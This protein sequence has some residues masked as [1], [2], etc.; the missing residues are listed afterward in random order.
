MRW[1]VVLVVVAVLGGAAFWL[2]DSDGLSRSDDT[3]ATALPEQEAATPVVLPGLEEDAEPTEPTTSEPP[4]SSSTPESSS[5]EDRSPRVSTSP[6]GI[7][8]RCVDQNG[9]GLPGLR[10]GRRGDASGRVESDAAG[11]IEWRQPEGRR[12]LPDSP[13]FV[14]EGRGYARRQFSVELSPGE[15]VDLGDLVIERGGTLTGWVETSAG[16]RLPGVEVLVLSADSGEEDER[17]ARLSGPSDRENA[18]QLGETDLR[19]RFQID[20]VPPGWVRLWTQGDEDHRWTFS[21]PVEVRADSHRNGITLIVEPLADEDRIEGIVY[22]PDGSP[23]PEAQVSYRYRAGG[24]SGSGSFGTD[25]AGRFRRLTPWRGRYRLH[26][27]DP[28]GELG[29]STVVES[30][31]GDQG[32]ELWLREILRVEVLVQDS[33]R[34]PVEEF[35]VHVIAAEG[36][37]SFSARNLRAG[38]DTPG[39]AIVAAP[40]E[41]FRVRITAEG[42]DIA[43]QGPFPAEAPPSRLVFSLTRV[44]GLRGIVTSHGKP[45]PGARVEAFEVIADDQAMTVN[46]FPARSEPWSKAQDT[47][48]DQGAFELGVRASGRLTVRARADGFAPVEVGPFEFDAAVGA[49]GLE[50][51]LTE[52]GTLR[53]R[54]EPVELATSEGVVVGLS[55][56]DGFPVTRPPGPDGEVVF[57]HLTPGPW[58]VSRRK[59]MLNPRSTSTTQGSVPDGEESES[60]PANCQVRE[61]SVTTFVLDLRAM[62]A[63]RLAGALLVDGRP[64][65]G[66]RVELLEDALGTKS[67]QCAIRPDGRFELETAEV[68]TYR[69][70]FSG[71]T[72]GGPVIQLS[73]RIELGD[74]P[75][76]WSLDMATGGI[77]GS[78]AST[79]GAGGDRLHYYGQDSDGR[80]VEVLVLVGDDGRFSLPQVPVGEGHLLLQRADQP[81]RRRTVTIGPGTITRVDF[82]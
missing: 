12:T 2:L 54:V 82:D 28:A 10:F 40:P 66:W 20:G 21:E 30:V 45:H 44:P 4:V 80:R 35:Q 74:T 32:I 62:T 77:E 7:D 23:H 59:Q 57:E 65:I 13:P 25:A 68:G 11:R 81:G 6:T 9:I 61:G 70:S 16:R 48:D 67:D 14:L 79:E 73:E 76:T 3:S 22:R 29:D 71:R 34:E 24:R 58:H 63:I 43:E 26:G 47:T 60:L 1:I 56:G 27:T 46:G 64:P 37:H 53:V 49:E 55:R 78:V 51:E 72:Q 8:A 17:E 15:I 42:F 39:Q 50:L 19:G 41:A 75:T 33:Q 18:R 52:G 69:L 5:V 38:E 31:P 36:D